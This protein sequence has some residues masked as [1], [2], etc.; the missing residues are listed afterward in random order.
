MSYK[1]VKDI[2]DPL[3]SNGFRPIRQKGS[4]R[5]YTSGKLVVVVLV[6]GK[7]GIEKGSYYNILRQAGL[8]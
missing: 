7:K 6:H 2:I 5:I 8:K 1:T 4:H 3:V